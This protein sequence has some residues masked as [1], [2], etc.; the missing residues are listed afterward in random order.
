LISLSFCSSQ[1][2]L[3]QGRVDRF[4]KGKGNIE[5]AIGGGVEFATK[6]F[7]GRNKIG[8][9]R[10]IITYSLTIATDLF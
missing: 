9:S 3:S 1:I 10:T 4:Y 2:L 8:L 7:A 5:V 6:Y